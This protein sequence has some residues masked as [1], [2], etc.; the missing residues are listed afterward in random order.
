MKDLTTLLFKVENPKV[1]PRAGHVLVAEPFIGDECFNHGVVS[2]IDYLSTEGATGVVLNNRSEY[3]LDELLDGIAPGCGVPVFCGG[4]QGQD[5]LYFIHTLGREIISGARPYGDGL[6]VG[7]DF[8]Q[9]IAYVNKG[10]PV[11]GCIRFFIGYTSWAC[12][13]LEEEILENRW[14]TVPHTI[15]AE[16]LLSGAADPFWH[17]Y[18]RSLGPLFRSWHLLPRNAACN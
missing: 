6:Y 8:T 9:A 2:V 10:Y 14:A 11:D 15:A 7:G 1:M 4:P 12:G 3:R 5:R 13:Q 18:V 16:E 17:R